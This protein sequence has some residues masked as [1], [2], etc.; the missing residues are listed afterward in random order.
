MTRILA[1]CVVMDILVADVP[2]KYAM[3]LS[4]SWA[5]KLQGTMQMDMTYATIP[6]FNQP[7]RL[8]READMK[9]MVT[10]PVKPENS[11]IF[12][13][14]TDLDSFILYNAEI[15]NEQEL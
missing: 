15:P 5:A 3:L 13:M 11:P 9:F 2:P 6:V 12:S 14:H 10:S 7:R 4:K 8:H 1:K